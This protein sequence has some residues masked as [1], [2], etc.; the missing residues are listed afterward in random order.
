LETSALA[1]SAVD[2][3]RGSSHILHK[4]SFDVGP[5][6]IVGLLGRNG[7]GKT[8]CISTIFGFLKPTSG[9]I[10]VFGSRID[11][12][13]PED[14][15]RLGVSIVPQGRRVFPSLTVQEHLKIAERRAIGATANTWSTQEIF[16]MFP[17]LKERRNVEARVLSGGEQQMLA[18]GR[19]LAANPR[20]LLMDEPSEGLAPM[21]VEEVGRSIMKLKE[22]GLS[23]LLVEQN[24]SLA[25]RLADEVVIMNVGTIALRGSAAVV[26]NDETAL[27][28]YLGVH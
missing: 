22:S 27:T 19:A 1:L 13:A 18:I 7:A 4:V 20:L 16:A 15:V 28:R 24:T 11:G 12:K 14:I 6:R 17:R 2:V 23:I 9:E 21:I 26:A 5:G 25:L 10:S 3:S 8:T